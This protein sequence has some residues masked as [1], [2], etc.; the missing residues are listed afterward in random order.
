MARNIE[1]NVYVTIAFSRDSIAWKSLQREAA[2]LDISIAHLIKV[3]LADR[4][5]AFQGH[6]KHVWFPREGMKG[7]PDVPPPSVPEREPRPGKENQ[8]SRRAAAASAA[9]YWNE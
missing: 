5:L 4:T 7:Q 6:G 2:D 3:L 1:E 9:Q 8:I